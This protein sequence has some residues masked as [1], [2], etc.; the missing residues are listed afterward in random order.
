MRNSNLAQ[1]QGQKPV[2]QNFRWG[3]AIFVI[4]LLSILGFIAVGIMSLFAG[5]DV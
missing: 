5:V 2:Q 1:F 4:L 3:Y